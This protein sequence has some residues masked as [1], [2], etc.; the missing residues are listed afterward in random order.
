MDQRPN[1]RWILYAEHGVCAGHK[2]DV[3]IN[4]L[5]NSQQK[6]WIAEDDGP[7]RRKFLVN[8]FDR[9]EWGDTHS[10]PVQ[11]RDDRYFTTTS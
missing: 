8:R 3:R 10:R 11:T 1:V 5:T 4:V 6:A 2:T 7:V 9:F